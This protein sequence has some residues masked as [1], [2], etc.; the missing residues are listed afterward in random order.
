MFANFI[1]FLVALILYTTCQHPEGAGGMP[2]HALV[3]ALALVGL[4]FIVCR[5]AFKRLASRSPL[6]AGVSLELRLDRTLSRLSVF[7]LLLFAADLYILKLKL[8][9]AGFRPFELFPTLEALLFLMGFV[10][11][12]VIVW[13]AAWGVQKRF[14]PGTVTSKSF[15]LSNISF[16]LPALLPWFLL[17]ITADIIQILPF[18]GPREFLATPA[19]EIIY[20]LLFLFA[21]ASFGPVMIQKLWGCSS[22]EQGPI[23]DRIEALCR[24]ARLGYADILKWEL[25]GGSMIT[26]GVMGLVARFRYIL[27][28]P[29]LVTLLSPHEIDAV[30]AHEIG[31][32]KHRH[33]HFYLLFFAGYIVCVYALF[34]PLFMLIYYL[35]PMSSAASFV[36]I[37]Q[38]TGSTLVFSLVLILLFLLYFRFGFGFFMRN[39]ERQ[40]D[41]HVYSLLG[42]AGALINTFYKISRFSRT[43]PDRPNWHHFSITE[44]IRF[45]ERCEENPALVGRHNRK[46]RRMVLGYLVAI[47]LMA[48]AGYSLNFGAGG[49]ALNRYLAET[50]LLR[51]LE[52]DPGNADLYTMIGDYYYGKDMFEQAIQAYDN[53][54]RI[55]PRNVHALNNLAWLLATCGDPAFLDYEK[56]LELSGKAVAVER[57]AH[58]LDTYAEACWLNGREREA[59][60]A[61][62]EALDKAPDRPEYYRSQVERFRKRLPEGPSL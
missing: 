53:V 52:I 24:S 47:V 20:V 45:L 21:V 49:E 14:F 60:E 28:T 34:D 22:L 59:L 1:Y 30:I 19:G 43:S 4:F 25:F 9:F 31:H 8:L 18:D 55:A 12:L 57:A 62:E 38:E 10:G 41:T 17:S 27:V 56:A 44:R 23:R 3:S 48:I 5:L 50:A 54:L 61:A 51:E 42:G 36:G 6:V 46:I 40:A 33:I 26:A 29:A 2:G 39:F 37:G 15:V 58:V 32:V 13:T 7:A 35:K 16:S 11:Y